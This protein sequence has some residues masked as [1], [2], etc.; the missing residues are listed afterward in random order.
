[1]RNG[2][3]IALTIEA[4]V[5]AAMTFVGAISGIIRLID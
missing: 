2:P 4:F 3:D 1:M 5:L